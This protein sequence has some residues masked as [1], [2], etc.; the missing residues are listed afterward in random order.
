MKWRN[1]SAAEKVLTVNSLQQWTELIWKQECNCLSRVWSYADWEWLSFMCFDNVWHMSI[2]LYDTDSP[3][4]SCPSRFLSADNSC[5]VGA[6]SRHPLLLHVLKRC[7][8]YRRSSFL[9]KQRDK[10]VM[11]LFP[12]HNFLRR[13][14][15]RWSFTELRRLW[16]KS[17]S[18]KESWMGCGTEDRPDEQF[19]SRGLW[20]VQDCGQAGKGEE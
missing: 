12:S 16:D 18:L 17:S 9:S 20:Q 11:L 6:H 8:K 13:W 5:R 3:S 19:S 1:M 2:W 14:W 10:C 4:G 7:L 15:G